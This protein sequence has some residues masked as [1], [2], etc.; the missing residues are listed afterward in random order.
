MGH[1]LDQGCP[2]SCIMRY[3]SLAVEQAYILEHKRI[4]E[5]SARVQGLAPHGI[6]GHR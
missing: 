5:P 3:V 6:G 4:A 1:S 2:S